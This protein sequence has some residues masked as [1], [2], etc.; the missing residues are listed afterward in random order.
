MLGYTQTTF[1][2]RIQFTLCIHGRITVSL[3]STY[4]KPNIPSTE[5]KKYDISSN[6][7]YPNLYVYFTLFFSPDQND[8]R[9]VWPLL[10][11]ETGGER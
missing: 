9:E 5:K 8:Y 11:V 10:I 3:H 6:L 4:C 7:F 2:A 1:R